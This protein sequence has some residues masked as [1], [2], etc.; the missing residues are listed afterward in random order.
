MI[1]EGD[2]RGVLTGDTLAN[3][4]VARMAVDGIAI[5]VRVWSSP[6]EMVHPYS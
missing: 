2:V 6:K 1:K 4:T 3:G 5:C